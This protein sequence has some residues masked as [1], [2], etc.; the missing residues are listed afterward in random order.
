LGPLPE[1]KDRLLE[2]AYTLYVNGQC[3]LC[4]GP[5]SEC[6]NDENRGAYEVAD[7]TCHKQ[8]AIEEYTGQEKFKAEPGQR[9]YA[10]AIDDSVIQRRTFPPLVSNSGNDAGREGDQPNP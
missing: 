10:V 8:A 9:F 1:W 7:T 4:G 5:S 2:F 3:S 6:R